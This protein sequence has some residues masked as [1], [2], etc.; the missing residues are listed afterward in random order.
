MVCVSESRLEIDMGIL[1]LKRISTEKSAY[2]NLGLV[3][4]LKAQF[5]WSP[6]SATSHPAHDHTC[7][8]SKGMGRGQS[9][10]KDRKDCHNIEKSLISTNIFTT[11]VTRKSSW[12]QELPKTTHT[13]GSLG[14][15]QEVCNSHSS[16]VEKDLIQITK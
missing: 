11:E 6:Y 5:S 12:L 2:G 7:C 3:L 16:Q 9:R 14:M 1:E 8:M 4:M 15:K 13:L 10:R